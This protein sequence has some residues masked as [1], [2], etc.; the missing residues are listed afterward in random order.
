MAENQRSS[1]TQRV[2]PGPFLAKVVN[3]LDPTYMG[4]LEVAVIKGTTGKPDT[5]SA[6]VIVKYCSP[7]F[8]STSAAFEGNNSSDFKDV[9]K[10]YGFW[11]VPPDIGCTVMVIFID[12]DINQGYWFGCVPDQY[13]NQ[14][15]PGIAASQYSAVGPGDEAKYGT[16][17]LPVAEFHKASRDMS[18][19]N[20]DTFTKAIHPFADR[21]VQQGL[22]LDTIRGVTSSS[23][24]REVPSQ[25]FGISTPGP[26]DTS[27]NAPRKAVGFRDGGGSVRIPTSRLGG[28]TFVMDDGDKDGQ[29][30]LVRIRT[31]TGHQILMHNSSDLIYIANSKGSAWVELSSN[32][33]IDIYAEDSISIHSEQDFNFRADR[34]VNFEAGRNINMQAYSGMQ[35]QCVDRFYLTCDNE[36]KINISNNLQVTAGA[37][38]RMKSGDATSFIA[39]TDFKVK[40]SANLNLEAGTDI[41]QSAGGAWKISATGNSNITSAEH[42]ETAGRIEMN[43]P[44]AAAAIASGAISAEVPDKLDSFSVPARSSGS[45]WTNGNFYKASNITSI[46]QRVP[47]HEPWD[48]H[49][50]INP[51]EFTPGR[52]DT[53]VNQ[54]VDKKGSPTAGSTGT[55]PIND[56]P[57]S[58]PL[59]KS[60]AANEQ[61]LQAVLVNAGITSP[62]KLASWMAQCKVESAG[63]RALKE[64]ASGAEY[65]GRKD[66]GN[67]QSGDGIRYKGRG[68]I[69]LTGR[70]VYKKMTK[71]FKAGIDFEQQPELVE[72]LEWAA[73]SVLYFFNVYKPI[74]FKNKTMTQ[75]YADSDAFWDDCP[76]VSALV[77]GGTNGLAQRKQYYAEYKTKF[78]TSGITPTGA[79]GTTSGVLTSGDGSPVQTGTSPINNK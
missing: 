9:Q 69:Q 17:L 60:A 71:Y 4:S 56:K 30:E 37:E 73:K 11:M 18:V 10:S 34:D 79:V 15:T 24:R 26:V 74:G 23:A 44:A 39:G 57:V 75:A 48:Q 77:N 31:R 63:F 67:T 21:L 5:E 3:H 43:G 46:M 66:L 52:L 61:Y 27:V 8:G 55:A 68:F 25:V 35:L 51:S 29:N 36:G 62:I 32:G 2:N 7:F 16:K 20:P 1:Q 49:E 14:M 40:A 47:M 28:S 54:Q 38:L 72:Q 33:K 6:N 19:P 53:Q 78:Q 22:L 58:V 12:G 50:N 65:E 13:Q 70:D 64:F 45:G 76:S 42:R 59:S 41:N